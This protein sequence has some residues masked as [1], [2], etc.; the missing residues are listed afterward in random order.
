MDL[1][2]ACHSQ[3]VDRK[4]RPH[5]GNMVAVGVV[6]VQPM[7]VVVVQA[8]RVG[9]IRVVKAARMKVGVS[10]A[11]KVVVILVQPTAAQ[12]DRMTAAPSAPMTDVQHVLR[13]RDQP[14]PVKVSA[15][16][17]TVTIVVQLAARMRAQRGLGM[18]DR[19]ALVMHD[20][21]VLPMVAVIL[22]QHVMASRHIVEHGRTHDH[23]AQAMPAQRVLAMRDLRVRQKV[24]ALSLGLRVT[25]LRRHVVQPVRVQAV[26]PVI[27]REHG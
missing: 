12:P 2:H 20:L 26:L 3:A 25:D 15:A 18:R 19:L 17:D 24:H 10:N 11:P 14:G 22:V 1:S 5:H 21:R 16:R 9:R 4:I 13:K 8:I 23:S 7:Q 27:G 6:H